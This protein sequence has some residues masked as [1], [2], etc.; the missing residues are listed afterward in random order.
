ML[1]GTAAWRRVFTTAAFTFL[2]VSLFA[3]ADD[4]NG[5]FSSL[6]VERWNSPY[7]GT[8]LLGAAAALAVTRAQGRLGSRTAEPVMSWITTAAAAM[9][10]AA[11]ALVVPVV[12]LV[13]AVID[14]EDVE[15]ALVVVVVLSLASAVALVTAR[16]MLS[17]VR[18]NR[19]VVLGILGVVLLLSV[20][21]LGVDHGQDVGFPAS[22]WAI[23][24][25][26]TLPGLAAYALTVPAEVRTALGPLVT[27][28]AYP[29]AAG[30]PGHPQT[31][32]QT[33]G[34]QPAPPPQGWPQQS[35][36]QP[37]PAG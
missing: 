8:F 17:D 37:P 6:F 30:Y 36:Q 11:V 5:L 10:V 15:P 26:F 21:S 4:G 20:I 18:R 29:P 3:I 33:P 25:W 7:A 1:E 12:S 32:Q 27:P 19:T 13:L 23:A 28:R 31:G 34:Y 16:S 14:T 22:G 24:M 35:Q 9:L 2:V